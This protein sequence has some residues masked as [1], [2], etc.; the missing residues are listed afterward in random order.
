MYNKVKFDIPRWRGKHFSY[1]SSNN[2]GWIKKPN[3]EQNVQACD[4]TKAQQYY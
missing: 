2:W 3:D 4:A 1:K